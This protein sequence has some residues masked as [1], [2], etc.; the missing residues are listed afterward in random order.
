MRCLFCGEE[1]TKGNCSIV[2]DFAAHDAAAVDLLITHERKLDGEDCGASF[3]AF[4]RAEEGVF[5]DPDGQIIETKE[6]KA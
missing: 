3:N 4:P 5:Y 1:M 6:V 2:A